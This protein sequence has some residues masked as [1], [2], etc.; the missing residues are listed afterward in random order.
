VGTD[1]VWAIP[2]AGAIGYYRWNAPIDMVISMAGDPMGTLDKR[3]R[4]VFLANVRALLNAG[5]IN[6]ADYLAILSSLGKTLEPEIVTAVMN[7]LGST[8]MAFVTDDLRDPFADYIR[9]T[10]G[11]AMG[12]FGLEKKDG[13]AE[14][15]STL[16]PRLLAWLGL[17]G[18]RQDVR[19]HC[20]K[21]A[22][23][24]LADPNAIDPSLA[25]VA[26]MVAAREGTRADFE[27]FKQRFET[28]EVPA[29]RNRFLSAL[30]NFSDEALQDEVLAYLLNGPVG[31]Y[32][33]FRVVGGISRTAAGRD[34]VYRWMTDNYEVLTSK[35]PAIVASYMPYFAGGCSAERLAAAQRFFAEP[36]HNVEGTDNNMAK[37]AD[38]ATDCVNLREREGAAVADFL[39]R[40]S[41]PADGVLLSP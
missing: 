40:Q 37:V 18:N 6:G 4:A 17:Q 7:E 24:Y 10:L 2:N 39:S 38:Q 22:E 23:A 36:E 16:R 31:P 32:D 5:E 12:R 20:R 13:E 35:F 25:W 11:P 9:A 3:E 8:E 1:V 26:L 21:M 27:T 33:M 30:G 19:R 14:S 15:V 41:R 28:A 34:K 29:E